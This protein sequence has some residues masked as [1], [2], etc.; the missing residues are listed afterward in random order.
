MK[1]PKYTIGQMLIPRGGGTDHSRLF[2]TEITTITCSAG[3]Q[4]IYKGTLWFGLDRTE[5]RAFTKPITM[6]EVE[7]L[8][9][10]EG[11]GHEEKT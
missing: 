7:I 4:I 11:F 3:T 10:D 9:L 5:R 6:H 8:C 1:E 2:V